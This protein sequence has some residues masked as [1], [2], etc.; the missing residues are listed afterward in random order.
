M[1]QPKME[2]D[3]EMP[4][5]SKRSRNERKGRFDRIDREGRDP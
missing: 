1:K 5:K 3:A 2:M 4:F